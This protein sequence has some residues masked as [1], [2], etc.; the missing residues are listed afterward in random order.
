MEN[1]KEFIAQQL[2]GRNFH[3]KCQCLFPLDFIGVVKGYKIQGDEIIWKID[4][5]G[6]LIDI[7]MNH[8]NMTVE[9]V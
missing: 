5:E 8:P 3:F 9:E 1:F 7:G 6:K 4:N 2:I